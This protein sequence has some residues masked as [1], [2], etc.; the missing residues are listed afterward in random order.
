[1][2]VKIRLA[3][4]GRKKVPFYRIVVASSDAPR[5]GKYIEKIGTYDPMLEKTN[6]SR[7]IM[8]ADRV[9]YWLEQGAQP[10]SR[11]LKF[12]GRSAIELPKY[13]Q[14]QYETMLAKHKIAP[15]KDIDQEEKK[16]S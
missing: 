16:S 6:P 8:K 13:I 9:S 15:K 5:D 2:V 7:V 1:M 11:M 4:F 3:R 12:I 10:T 14:K